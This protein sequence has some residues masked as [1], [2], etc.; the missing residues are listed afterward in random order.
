MSALDYV[1]ADLRGYD[2]YLSARK[3]NSGGQVLLN[4]N[5]SPVAQAF[6]TLALNRYPEPQPQRLREAMAAYYGTAAEQLLVTRGSD[7]AIDL[8][9]R[10]AC[11]P[12]Q[13]RVA[14]QSPTFGM[15]A[16]CARLHAAEVIDIPLLSDGKQFSWNVQGMIE[17]T[18]A[19]G[20]TVL[21]LC[22]PANPTGQSLPLAQMQGLLQ[23]LKGRCLVV[24]DEA[25]GEYST[26]P[27]A[28]SLLAQY[29][30]LAV[31]KT[32]S[33]AHALAGARVGGVIADPALIAVLKACQAPYPIAKPSAETALQAL[34]PQALAATR[35]AVD[36]CL[37][38]RQRLHNALLALQDVLHVYPSDANFLL[39]RF[40]NPEQ[41]HAHLLK[42]GIVVRAMAQYPA[43]HDCLRITVGSAEEN[44]AL[45]THLAEQA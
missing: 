43:L 10:A 38:Q 24:I 28:L 29:E 37:E 18:L 25:Y 5:E 26:Q 45:L 7:E 6:D 16:V 15:Y 41:Q 35:S 33:K 34:S 31:L 44:N 21:F 40:R 42:N 22:S 4:A 8:L 30:N 14:I 13:G 20:A 27:S 23:A 2:G 11:V 17:Q 36:L 3:Q 32:L 9:I 1:R 39:V 19:N 12:G